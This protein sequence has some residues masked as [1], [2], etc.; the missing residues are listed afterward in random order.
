MKIQQK[1]SIPKPTPEK[2]VRV[3]AL[4][5]HDHHS[6]VD[7]PK[8][9]LANTSFICPCDGGCPRCTPVIQLKPLVSQPG[10]KYEQ[11]ADRIAEQ[12]MKMPEPEVQ[13]TPG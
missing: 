3:S 10:D 11:E 4:R 12:I 13:A 5:S 2:S 6:I 8:A 9:Q 1:K 7:A